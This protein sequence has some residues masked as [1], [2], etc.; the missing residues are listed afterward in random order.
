MDK[1]GA[2]AAHVEIEIGG[3][4]AVLFKDETLT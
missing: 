3:A 2:S 1:G 4:D